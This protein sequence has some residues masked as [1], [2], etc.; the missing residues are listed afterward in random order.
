MPMQILGRVLFPRLQ[1]W[2]QRRQAKNLVAALL[3]A[4]IFA[5]IVAGIMFLT[6]A[7]R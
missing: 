2:Q 1:P 4:L 6:N 5:A 3:V 7:R